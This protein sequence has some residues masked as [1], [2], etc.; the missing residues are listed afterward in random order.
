[1]WRYQLQS[2]CDHMQCGDISCN[3]TVTICNVEIS[4]AIKLY[5]VAWLHLEIKVASYFE[6][7]PAGL[8]KN[9]MCH[10]WGNWPA[11]IPLYLHL[12]FPCRK[13]S[14]TFEKV[15]KHNLWE[16]I[17]SRVVLSSCSDYSWAPQLQFEPHPIHIKKEITWRDLRWILVKTVQKESLVWNGQRPSVSVTKLLDEIFLCWHHMHLFLIWSLGLSDMVPRTVWPHRP[18]ESWESSPVA[19]R[20]VS[21][22]LLAFYDMFQSLLW[23]RKQSV[24]ILI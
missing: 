19:L 15:R 14:L 17:Y 23:C 4:A 20:M 9:C 18:T 24:D 10:G 22:Q 16:V 21:S 3:Q 6:S 13:A 11:Q 2:N 1:M 7:I 5:R 12:R 8:L